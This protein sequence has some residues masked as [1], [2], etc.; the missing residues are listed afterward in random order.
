MWYG[1]VNMEAFDCMAKVAYILVEKRYP[2]AQQRL[3]VLYSLSRA[4]I[5]APNPPAAKVRVVNLRASSLT[6]ISEVLSIISTHGQ[7]V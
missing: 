2:L 5:L 1:M 4:R 6:S 7:V 3:Q